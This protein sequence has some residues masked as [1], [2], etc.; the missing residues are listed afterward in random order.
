MSTKAI[1]EALEK[2]DAL[3]EAVD[4]AK[5]EAE[6]I[7]LAAKAR[8]EL[9]V[10]IALGDKDALESLAEMVLKETT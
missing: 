10:A 2:M 1:R 5:A 7:E 4:D 8:R 3:G 6:A 9:A